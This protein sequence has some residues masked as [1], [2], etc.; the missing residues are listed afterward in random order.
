VVELVPQPKS[1]VLPIDVTIG[2]RIWGVAA[3][4]RQ[5]SPAS[6]PCGAVSDILQSDVAIYPG[7]GEL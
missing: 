6:A 3:K 4:Q 5:K 7:C 1:G 2:L